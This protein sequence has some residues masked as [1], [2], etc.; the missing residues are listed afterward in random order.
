M[1][2]TTDSGPS[3]P[4]G[5]RSQLA[6]LVEAIHHIDSTGDIAE[7]RR[8]RP[9]IF[10]SFAFWRLLARLEIE[11]KDHELHAWQAVV[12]ASASAHGF[13]QQQ[14]RLGRA[15][16]DAG[17]DERRVLA[18]LRAEG[19]PLF[20]LVRS[21]VHM[22]ASQSVRFDHRELA[23]LLLLSHPEQ[24]ERVRRRIARDFFSSQSADAP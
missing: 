23:Q 21:A 3:T 24:R 17:V 5:R 1:T 20:D 22:L 15:L 2:L 12:V 9:G 13:H 14:R 6:R 16:A 10:P 11:P 4:A 8:Q 7:L 18:L 19:P